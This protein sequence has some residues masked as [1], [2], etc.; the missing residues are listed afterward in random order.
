[1]GGGAREAVSFVGWVERS[2]T[3]RH[4]RMTLMGF[5][6]LYPSYALTVS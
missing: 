1:M 4:R 2:D 3:H 5:A 6:L